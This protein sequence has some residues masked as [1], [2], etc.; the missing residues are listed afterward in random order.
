ML[1]EEAKWIQ[2][3]LRNNFSI[4]NYPLLNIGSSTAV[5]R[6]KTQ[7]HI[8]ESVFKP[9]K[10]KSLRVIHTDIK[11]D[12]GVDAVGDLND[13]LFRDSLKKMGIKSVL[14]SNLL[15]H[16]E[17]PKEICDAIMDLLQPNDLIIV[18]VPHY[19]P[20]HKDPIDT[21]LR[22]SIAELHNFFPG[23]KIVEAQIV[24]AN[25]CY[26][27]ALLS[28]PKYFLIMALRLFLPFYKYKEWRLIVKDFF[29]INRKY[30]ACCLLLCKQAT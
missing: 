11:E 27:N 28:N 19:F 30:S 1:I 18:T 20:F 6:E 17:H 12:A 21:M 25:D 3:V 8:H 9:L 14:C 16:L 15:E 29:N 2:N 22:P 13:P 10:E 7:A 23:T 5:F 26:K 24:D 4:E